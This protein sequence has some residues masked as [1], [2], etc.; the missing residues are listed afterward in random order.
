[1]SHGCDLCACKKSGSKF[2]KD[3]HKISGRTWP[4]FISDEKLHLGGKVKQILIAYYC[5]NF[6][7]KKCL[8]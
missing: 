1:M 4:D 8:N 7:A 5:G 2:S 3:I 6:S